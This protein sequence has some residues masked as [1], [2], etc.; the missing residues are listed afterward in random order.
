MKQFTFKLWE[1][2]SPYDGSEIVAIISNLVRPSKNIKTGPMSQLWILPK[3]EAPWEAIKREGGD[4]CV[5][6]DCI[7]TP[8]RAKRARKNGHK[9]PSC[10]VGRVAFRAPSRVWSGINKSKVQLEEGLKAIKESGFPVRYGAYGD[11][12]MLPLWLIKLVGKSALEATN[13]KRIHTAYTHQPHRVWASHLKSTAM[14]S[15]NSGYDGKVYREFGWRTFRVTEKPEVDDGEI[16]C[17]NFTH[18]VQCIAC[19]LCDGVRGP[20]DKR[21][22]I[23]I[24]KH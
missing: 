1:G 12:A 17:P 9:I 22:S 13:G 15:V 10:Y 2:N 20:H 6:G 11:P 16:I 18:G 23:T 14:A 8:L 24:P 4:N 21:K 19:G 7:Y 5:C 3:N